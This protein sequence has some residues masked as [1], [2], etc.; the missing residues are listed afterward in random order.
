MQWEVGNYIWKVYHRRGSGPGVESKDKQ[1]EKL[2]GGF[3]EI[4]FMLVLHVL[5][6]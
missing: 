2:P 1:K 3:Q 4:N 5:V 6:L